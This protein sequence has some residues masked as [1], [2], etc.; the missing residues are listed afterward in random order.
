MTS[1]VAMLHA[2]ALSA[3][4]CRGVLIAGNLRVPC[5]FGRSGVSSLKREGDGATP[6]GIWPLRHVLV[7]PGIRV[8]GRLLAYRLARNDGWCDDPSDR[9]YNHRVKLPYSAS[10]EPLWRD[11]ELYDVIVVLGYN[12][13][14]RKRGA[15]SAVFFHLADPQS[16]PTAG[17]IAVSRKDMLKILSLCGPGTRLRVW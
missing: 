8:K 2:R 10:Y 13:R 9:N 7:R 1:T 16:G 15:G 11:D 17:C 4:A 3:S 5:A 12:D 6:R 14:P